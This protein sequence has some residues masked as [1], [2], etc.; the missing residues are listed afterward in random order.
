[1]A[2][3]T[4]ARALRLTGRKGVLLEGADADLVIISEDLEVCSTFV[5]GKEVFRA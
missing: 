4:P 2:T 1:M 5:G 3:L